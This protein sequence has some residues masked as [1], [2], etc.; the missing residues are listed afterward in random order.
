MGIHPLEAPVKNLLQQ[1]PVTLLLVLMVI[2]TP[3][4]AVDWRVEGDAEG[5]LLTQ[6][7]DDGLDGDA[8][9]ALS[10][11]WLHYDNERNL[12]TRATT[13]RTIAH[14]W[15]INSLPLVGLGLFQTFSTEECDEADW[16]FAAVQVTEQDLST[17]AETAISSITGL[18]VG[19]GVSIGTGNP[20]AGGTSGLLANLATKKL[21]Q[22]MGSGTDDLGS[23]PMTRLAFGVNDFAMTGPDGGS[24]VRLRDESFQSGAV[25]LECSGRETESTTGTMPDPD[26]AVAGI[27]PPLFTALE[28]TALITREDGSVDDEIL[29]GRESITQALVS[30]AEFAA[31]AALAEAAFGFEGASAA[32]PLMAQARIHQANE[33]WVEAVVDFRE[34]FRAAYTATFNGVLGTPFDLPSHMTLIAPTRSVRANSYE[35]FQGIVQG[36]SAT[37]TIDFI[38]VSGQDSGMEFFTRHGF[39]RT[40]V[41][42]QGALL[43]DFSA[44]QLLG[45]GRIS[46]GVV[47]APDAN[48]AVD[49]LEDGSIG[50]GVF[51]DDAGPFFEPDPDGCGYGEVVLVASDVENGGIPVGNGPD[52]NDIFTTQLTL[53]DELQPGTYILT[54]TA[55]LI[56]SNGGGTRQISAPITLIVPVIDQVFGDR[57]GG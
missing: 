11:D 43:P 48:C 56:D 24:T 35:E 21:L 8:E 39:E 50:A 30:A 29:A 33:E 1:G 28:E 13:S 3:A 15:D 16:I 49:H 55:E 44:N 5:L 40:A 32:L 31:L 34:A 6:N 26:A 46:G 18:A 22:W 2:A 27:F 51:I 4:M 53:T 7:E 37:E 47:Q 20:F 14:D 23:I 17:N 54:F 10:V 57:F 41:A 25:N 52:P 9:I 12:H 42:L 38:D 45:L 19:I 36:L